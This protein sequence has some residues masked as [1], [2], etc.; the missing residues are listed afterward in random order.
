MVTNGKSKRSALPETLER[1]WNL[2]DS[3]EI[4]SVDVS[5]DNYHNVDTKYRHSRSNFQFW[6]EETMLYE[7]VIE[8]P[9]NRKKVYNVLSQ[10]SAKDWGTKEVEEEEIVW[11][12]SD[13][14]KTSIA[15]VEGTIYLNC[16]GEIISGCDWSYNNQKHHKICDVIDDIQAAIIKYKHSRHDEDI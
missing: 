4:T 1:L 3:N 16:K 10:G 2:C 7:H 14:S 15:V 5:E 13:E 9:M 8:L 11:R 12:W 6:L